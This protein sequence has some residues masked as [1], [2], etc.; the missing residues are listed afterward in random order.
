MIEI[1]LEII[2]QNSGIK[3]AEEI[4]ELIQ[5]RE[6]LFKIHQGVTADLLERLADLQ[7]GPPLERER[8]EWEE[9]MKE[10]RQHLKE[11]K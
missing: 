3:A 2:Q 7:N 10:I 5:T 1:I 11:L 6:G 8:K 9:L 4:A